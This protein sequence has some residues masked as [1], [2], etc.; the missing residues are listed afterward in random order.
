MT[1]EKA[2]VLQRVCDAA[3]RA[4]GLDQKSDRTW[5]ANFQY[6]VSS[7]STAKLLW[8]AQLFDTAKGEHIS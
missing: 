2:L 5:Q 6:A 4:M 1:D 8:L 7:L 3:R